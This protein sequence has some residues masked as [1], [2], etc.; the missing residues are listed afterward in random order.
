MAAFGIGKTTGAGA[1]AKL[2]PKDGGHDHGVY[3]WTQVLGDL[4]VTV[5][6]LPFVPGSGS[7][8]DDENGAGSQAVGAETLAGNSS[9]GAAAA[10]SAVTSA[11]KKTRIPRTHVPP[12]S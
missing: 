11:T 8:G 10:A 5:P 12:D 6:L 9:D 4:T 7:D 1:V 2:A 3:S